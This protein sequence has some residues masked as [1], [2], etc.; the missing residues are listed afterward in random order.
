MTG[1][2]VTG[3]GA[4]TGTVKEKNIALDLEEI[5]MP[6]CHRTPSQRLTSK[7]VT[8]N[9]PK[10]TGTGAEA[11]AS[12]AAKKSAEQLERS[13]R[14]QGPKIETALTQLRT[15]QPGSTVQ[16]KQHC[17]ELLMNPVIKCPVQQ[18]N[19]KLNVHVPFQ[20]PP[21]QVV[22]AMNYA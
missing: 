5:S 21:I 6:M 2:G 4:E 14:F 17:H 22:H 3:A 10:A 19:C 12:A 20:D 16:C 18:A 9:S 15:N 13:V 11:G 8:S 1:P 7:R